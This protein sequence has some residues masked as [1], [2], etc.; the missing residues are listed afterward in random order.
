MVRTPKQ[1][2]RRSGFTLIE[3]LVVVAIISIL[4]S[5]T[6]VAVFRT[7]GTQQSSN[8]KSELSRLEAALKKA[9][10]SSADQFSK[11]PIPATDTPTSNHSSVYNTIVLPMAG[12]DR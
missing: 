4:I 6:A 3:M 12:G 11:E 2:V 5:L 7:I 1:A 9:W 8:T 10:R